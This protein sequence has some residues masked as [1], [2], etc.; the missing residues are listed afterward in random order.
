MIAIYGLYIIFWYSFLFENLDIS[1]LEIRCS[2]KGEI[3][4]HN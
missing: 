2:F 3:S 4:P 1:N